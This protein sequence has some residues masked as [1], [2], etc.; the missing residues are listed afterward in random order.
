M[1]EPQMTEKTSISMGLVMWLVGVTMAG[2]GAWTW[3]K[4]EVVQIRADVDASKR[5]DAEHERERV[6]QAA[7]IE[8]RMRNIEIIMCTTDDAARARLCADMGVLK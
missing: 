6:E 7:R 5:D 2:A 8:R 3:Q 1:N 4:S